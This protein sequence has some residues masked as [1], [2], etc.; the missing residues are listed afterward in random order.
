MFD[1]VLLLLILV[2]PCAPTHVQHRFHPEHKLTADDR[3]IAEH[4]RNHKKH[5]HKCSF[6]EAAMRSHKFFACPFH[7]AHVFNAATEQHEFV[8]HLSM[9]PARGVGNSG[10]R[11]GPTLVCPYDLTDDVPSKGYRAHVT[12]TCGSRPPSLP[13]VIEKVLQIVDAAMLSDGTVTAAPLLPALAR[14]GAILSCAWL[15]LPAH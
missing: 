14:L 9:C 5:K 7:A 15:H 8:Q 3:A 13:P 11:Y 10:S 1:D 6:R 4:Y 2:H 12:E